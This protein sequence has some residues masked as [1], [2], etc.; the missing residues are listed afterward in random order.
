M[1]PPADRHGAYNVAGRQVTSAATRAFCY[2]CLTGRLRSL[3]D[4]AETGRHQGCM[5]AYLCILHS[6][7]QSL[8]SLQV[9]HDL[10]LFPQLLLLLSLCW[11]CLAS[12]CSCRQQTLLGLLRGTAGWCCCLPI[13][14]RLS[15]CCANLIC[16]RLLSSSLVVNKTQSSMLEVLQSLQQPPQAGAW[17]AVRHCWQKLLPLHPQ[18][19]MH[20]LWWLWWRQLVRLLGH[21]GKLSSSNRADSRYGTTK[22][23]SKC[24][25]EM[26]S[27]AYM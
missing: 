26:E 13:H 10:L 9:C 21:E 25:R 6:R 19:V 18:E 1:N 23:R 4:P 7:S 2:K 8:L 14:R 12:L 3:T 24:L 17:A 11:L 15:M 22:Q 27:E 16:Q 5:S 20:V